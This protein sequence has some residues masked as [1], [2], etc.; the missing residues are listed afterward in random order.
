LNEVI[1]NL[2]ALRDGKTPAK[3]TAASAPPAPARERT[4]TAPPRTAPKATPRAAENPAA[5]E[6]KA[7]VAEPAAPDDGPIDVEALWQ[8]AVDQIRV[9]RPLIKGWIDSAK[10]LGNEGRNFLLGFPVEQTTAMET[11][12][13]P[14]FRDFLESV[15]KEISG[16]DWT[17]KFSVKEGLEVQAPKEEP[18]EA[19]APAR[20]KTEVAATLKDD[21]FIR[22]A[23]EIFKGEIKT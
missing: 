3:T 21:P 20:P 16:R 23:L 22:E 17:I 18:A 11:L 5:E 2:S 6:R 13:T 12:S 15:L 19:V 9:R 4:P 14:K 1:E 10:A 7:V 8:K